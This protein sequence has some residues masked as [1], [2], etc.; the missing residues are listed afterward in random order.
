MFSERHYFSLRVD[1]ALSNRVQQ[2]QWLWQ[3]CIP[4]WIYND[5]LCE[6]SNK[7]VFWLHNSS[8]F[9]CSIF[10]ED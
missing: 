7:M 6:G 2:I 1:M 5:P 8:D 9:E 10:L 3:C 4:Y